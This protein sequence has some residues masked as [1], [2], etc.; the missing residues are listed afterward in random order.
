MSELQDRQEK[1]S[2]VRVQPA[3]S[4][5]KWGRG[6]HKSRPTEVISCNGIR[7]TE[8][9]TLLVQHYQLLLNSTQRL[10]KT[11]QQ[12][13]VR[14]AFH[15]NSEIRNKSSDLKVRKQNTK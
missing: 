10:I 3:V 9:A 6:L 14:A 5:S 11:S 8:S 2:T 1:W 12:G 15:F 4:A 7:D 13:S